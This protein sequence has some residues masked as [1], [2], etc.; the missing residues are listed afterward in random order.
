MAERDDEIVEGSSK[1]PNVWGLAVRAGRENIPWPRE[2]PCGPGPTRMWQSSGQEN[3]R[4]AFGG[5]ANL[6][7]YNSVCGSSG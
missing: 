3:S 1:T 6:S 5:N 4:C 7:L 2:V